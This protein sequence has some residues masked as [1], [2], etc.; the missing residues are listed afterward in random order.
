MISPRL[1][2]VLAFVGTLVTLHLLLSIHPTYRD[3]TLPKAL[4]PGSSSSSVTD[5]T[6][7]DIP[8]AAVP[9][10]PTSEELRIAEE[11]NSSRKKAN[12]AFVVLARNSDLFEFLSSMRQVEDRFNHWARYD[13]VFLNDEP[14][15][16]QFKRYT[17]DLAS[18]ETKYGLIPKEIWEQPDWIDEDKAAKGRE[19]MIKMKVIYGH[20]VPY[21]NMCRFNSGYFF[22]HELVLPYDYYWRVEPGIKLFCDL[23]YDPF[24][25]MQE[26]EKVYG[27]TL[28]LL[29]YKETIPTL[30]EATKEF[31]K[32][33]PQYV[34]DGNA[35]DFISDDGGEDYNLC[36]F[37]SNFEIGDMRFW[38]SEAYIKYFEHLD[39]Q[40]GFYYER[41]GDAPVHSLAAALF[42]P[43]E[44]IHWFD[45]IG[46]RHE[47]FQH[48]PQGKSNR[49]QKCWCDEKD[50]F[51]WHGYS[52]TRRWVAQFPDGTIRKPADGQRTAPWKRSDMPEQHPLI[53]ATTA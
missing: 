47:P 29:E 39:K 5:E 8:E 32:E 14:F 37:W 18:G 24:L 40:G 25:L 53:N 38:R 48:C 2:Y 16:D 23:T 9:S 51:D 11:A 1:K 6:I 43:K 30:W 10:P 4:R 31:I 46:Y 26:Q 19:Q 52:C 28:S 15:D 41:W 12:A 44:K 33:N 17:S 3:H 36:H 20:S 50:S 49:D 42:L 22:R 34:V 35:V 45:D 7:V 21:R 27:F 13:W